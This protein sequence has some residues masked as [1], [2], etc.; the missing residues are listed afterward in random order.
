MFRKRTLAGKVQPHLA[1]N[2]LIRAI[3]T[4]RER[5]SSI[6]ASQLDLDCGPEDVIN[7][8]GRGYHLREWII[9]EQYDELGTPSCTV[10]VCRQTGSI[11]L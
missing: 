4:L 8:G 9:V 7:N 1:Q 3:K 10:G 11:M 6:M 2:T 5:I